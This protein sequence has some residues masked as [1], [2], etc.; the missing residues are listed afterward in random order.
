[1]TSLTED[2]KRKSR[3]LSFFKFK[4]AGTLSSHTE[5]MVVGTPSLLGIKNLVE[6]ERCPMSNRREVEHACTYETVERDGLP[7]WHLRIGRR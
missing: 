6:L 3:Y 2:D 1:M 5:S 7:I 4:L